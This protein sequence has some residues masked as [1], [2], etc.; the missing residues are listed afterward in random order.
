MLYFRYSLLSKLAVIS[1]VCFLIFSCNKPPALE[2]TFLLDEFEWQLEKDLRDDDLNGSMAMTIV[3]GNK[4]LRSK[5]FGMA[6]LNNTP[7]DTNNIYRVGSVS[8]SFTAFLMMLLVQDEIITL[9]EPVEKYVPEVRNITGYSDSTKFTF[10]ELASHTAGLAS[11][12]KTRY[13]HGSVDEW[14]SILLKVMP[15]V[16]FIDQPGKRY[17][18]SNV[19]F[20]IL[21][22]ALSRASQQPFVT[23][24]EQKVFLPLGMKNTFYEIPENKMK[25]LAAGRSGGPM[26]GYDD[27]RPRKEIVGRSFAVPNGG[28]WSTANDLARF[29]RCIMGYESL[30][31]KENLTIMLSTQTPPGRW[32]ENYSLGFSIYEDDVI[33]TIGH[34]GGTPGYRANFLFEQ[35]TEYGVILLRNYNWGVTDLNLRSTLLLRQL[36]IVDVVQP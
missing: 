35:E 19:A 31:N 8:K 3:K 5:A 36:K 30:L 34:Q 25:H 27:E 22:L 18:Y 21:G 23:L 15:A 12:P 7:A 14:E 26:G 1:W 20:A 4:V 6:D 28:I 29:M 13:I 10:R 9:D 2:E 11:I 17:A 16:Y 24:M 33:H 32:S